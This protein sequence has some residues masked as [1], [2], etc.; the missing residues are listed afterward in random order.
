M[1]GDLENTDNYA[2]SRN[3]T[4]S[5]LKTITYHM[6]KRVFDICCGLIGVLFLLPL[7]L[8]VK[9]LNLIEGDRDS[10]WYTQDRIGLNGKAF[11]LYKF[12]SM[13]TN[14]DEILEQTLELNKD[15]AK[16][17]KIHKKLKNDPRITKV[18]KFLRETSLDEWPQ[19]INVLNGSMSL[20]GNRPYLP[21]EKKDI[22]KY[23]DYVIETKPGLT[24][25]WQVSGRSKT[26]FEE[27]LEYDKIYTENIGIKQDIKIFFK[28]FHVV[29]KHIGAK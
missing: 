11:K 12:R 26:S 28:T 4:I 13:V 16:E 17:Y 24:G 15:L 18:G 8:L 25:L 5:H 3:R 1:F 23:Y 19:F 6:V 22:G 10:I 14:A 29:I 7:A 27:R 9:I 21:R 20:I 2:G